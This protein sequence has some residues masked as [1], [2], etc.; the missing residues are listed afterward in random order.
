MLNKISPSL[1]LQLIFLGFFR[2]LA[3]YYIAGFDSIVRRCMAKKEKSEK[4]D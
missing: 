1:P 2:L 3:L 4:T